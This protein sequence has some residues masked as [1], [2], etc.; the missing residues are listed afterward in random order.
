[1]PVITQELR[2][3]GGGQDTVRVSGTFTSTSEGMTPPSSVWLQYG[4]PFLSSQETGQERKVGCT[5]RAGK[6][7][8]AQTSED[9]GPHST[10]RHSELWLH[11][12]PWL[13]HAAT[14]SF[15]FFY[16]LTYQL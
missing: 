15:C 8:R 5:D 10:E 16:W 3:W 12:L 6:P 4:S 7:P 2:G 9:G 13:C 1:M 14:P 11:Y